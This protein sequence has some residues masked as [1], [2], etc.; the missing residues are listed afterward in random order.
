MC[1]SIVG[2]IFE[3]EHVKEWS[4]ELAID[5]LQRPTTLSLESLGLL[6]E[7]PQDHFTLDALGGQRGGEIDGVMDGD[8]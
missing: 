4:Y 8:I 7:F 2:D 5:H 6:M 3:K 1:S